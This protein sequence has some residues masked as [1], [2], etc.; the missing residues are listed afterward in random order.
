MMRKYYFLFLI[1]LLFLPGH[2]VSQ[3]YQLTGNPINTTGWTMVS[4]T[5]PSDYVLLTENIG[6]KSGSIRLNS[7]IN[8]KYCDKW[9]VEFDFRMETPSGAA[10]D[11]IA[12]WYLANPPTTSV[13]GA[14]LGI[15]K[16]AVG[17]MVA[18]D[19][20]NNMNPSA[21]Y[22]SKVHVAYGEVANTTDNNNIEFY[23][24]PGSSF[25][26]PNYYPAHSFLSSTFKHVI[27]DGKVDPANPIAWIVKISID[28]MPVVDQSFAPSG[29]AATMTQG[30]F[31][32]S[33]STGMMRA[34]QSIKN[35]KVFVDKI[36]LLQTSITKSLCPDSQGKATVDLTSFNSQLTATPNLYN[37]T[38]YITGS[39]TP[40]ANPTN[41][42]YSSNT[43]I[44]VL[45]KDPTSVLCDNN[46]TVITLNINPTPTVTDATLRSCT[47]ENS[48]PPTGIF[49]LTTA[50]VTTTTGITKKYYP[51]MSDA[52]NGTNEI[53]NPASYTSQAGTVYIKVANSSDCYGIAKVTLE[54]IPPVYSNT[55]KDQ[56]ICIEDKITLDAGP[57]FTSYLWNTG[58]V[59]QT[60]NVGVGS[61]WVK[62]KSG[63][64]EVTQTVKILPSE[65]PVI[66][67][68]EI[69][70]S[71]VIVHVKG[72][73]PPYKYSLDGIYWQDSNEFKNVVRGD[74]K[75]Y[76]KDAYDCEPIDVHIVVPNLVNVITPNGDG[77]NDMIDYSA[78]A[79]KQNL[80]FNVFDRYGAKIFQADKSNGY[81]WN[82]TIGGRK[83]PT[84]NYWY[85]VS[86]N[87]NDKKNTEMKYSGW[88]LVKNRD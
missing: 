71:T 21:G 70:N 28:G 88:V 63:T 18:L 86:W 42:E 23:N 83:V 20:Y 1:F 24:V 61:Y 62:L 27:I 54:T 17:F 16:N 22:M 41:F 15:S 85:S 73:T 51:T 38:Y 33:A 36:P 72:G 58:A 10:A 68:I 7:P 67:N 4:A 56:I 3:T 87:E 40:I 39:G 25:H 77:I 49:N 30:Y 37:F 14:G 75:V 43:S 60:I 44:T 35:V 2:F 46:D 84:G 6:N 19:N 78:L 57:G 74:A 5:A 65:Q 45:I 48:N 66:K 47:I 76:V 31:G 80:V 55:L 11:G 79:G 50:P 82:G 29:A 69:S 52:Q 53:M 34:A 12:F 26:S 32:F 8:L 59:T 13:L 9:R 64:C 81:K